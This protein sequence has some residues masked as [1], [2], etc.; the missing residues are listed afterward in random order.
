MAQLAQMGLIVCY[1]NIINLT[2]TFLMNTPPQKKKKHGEISG[3]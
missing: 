3:G 1:Q 2:L